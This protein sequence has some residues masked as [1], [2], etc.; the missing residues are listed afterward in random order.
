MRSRRPR[1]VDEIRN[2]HWFFEQ[3]LI[4]A[5]ER[6]LADY[7]TRLPGAPPPLRFGSW[8]GGDLDGN[9]HTGAET[10]EEALER[11]R[12]LARALLRRDVLELARTWGISSQLVDVDPRVGGERVLERLETARRDRA[13]VL[14]RLVEGGEFR[15]LNAKS[16]HEKSKP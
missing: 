8:I 16:P 14:R 6:L 7:R 2:G 5:A 13:R 10:L 15:R 9:P 11:A 4:D 1:V 12:A 3:S